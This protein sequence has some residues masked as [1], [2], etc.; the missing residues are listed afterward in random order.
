MS[1]LA[2]P[3]FDIRPVLASLSDK[4][5]V[6]H[7]EADFQ[8]A[9]A[10][11]SKLLYP[12]IE[13]RLE[14]H[15]KENPAL[16]LD[17]QI[18][19]RHNT[20]TIAVE[21]KYLTREWAGED[22]GETFALKTHSAH[23]IKRYDVVKDIFRVEDFIRGRQSWRGFAVVLTNVA[24]YWTVPNGES[25][26]LDAAFRIHDNANLAG[27]LGW[28]AITG[29]A[30]GRSGDISLAGRYPL[31]WSDYSSLDESSAGKFRS[32]IVPILNGP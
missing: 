22:A 9:F 4:R 27:I 31:R 13:V 3:V 17:V 15:P 32:L 5:R 26:S 16:R 2:P 7:S 10:W 21:L 18:L 6:F 14:T 30:R 8:F 11:E 23:D 25:N 29:T 28:K 12:H 20:E 24:A 1:K 19:D